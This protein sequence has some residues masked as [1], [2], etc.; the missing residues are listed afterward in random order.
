MIENRISGNLYNEPF[1][2]RSKEKC[3]AFH[4]TAWS[5]IVHK[6]T[7]KNCSTPLQAFPF[8]SLSLCILF[9]LFHKSK[10]TSAISQLIVQHLVYVFPILLRF[11]KCVNY[12][13]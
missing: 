2:E 7:I 1:I 10:D 11:Q 3:T 9:F 5:L 13:C 4:S 12:L 6:S 8:R